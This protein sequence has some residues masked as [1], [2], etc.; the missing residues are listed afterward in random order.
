M[1]KALLFWERLYYYEC[2]KFEIQGVLI[3]QH[4]AVE[5]AL[6]VFNLHFAF[7]NCENDY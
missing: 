6:E 5:L 7:L 4:L 2:R 1:L 3:V